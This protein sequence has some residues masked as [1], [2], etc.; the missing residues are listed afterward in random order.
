MSFSFSR[1]F[2]NQARELSGVNVGIAETAW[3]GTSR[4]GNQKRRASRAGWKVFLSE[5][6]QDLVVSEAGESAHPA[7]EAD[8]AALPTGPPLRV[9]TTRPTRSLAAGGV[10]ALPARR[11]C[12]R[13]VPSIWYV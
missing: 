10:T 9:S 4:A 6:A 8:Q 11:T 2:L 13:R 1:L 3:R 12:S 7:S 5:G